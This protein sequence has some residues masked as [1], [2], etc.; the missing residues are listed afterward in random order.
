M[1]SD[2]PAVYMATNTVNG[3]RYIGATA[4]GFGA[5]KRRHL[6]RRT[7]DRS[8]PRFYDAIN[9]YGEGAF[10]WK[11]LRTF[12]SAHCAFTFER[13]AIH[14]LKPEYNV[15]GGGTGVLGLPAWNRTSVI[16]LEDGIVYTS[17][18]NAAAAYDASGGDLSEI[19][20]GNRFS[21]KGRHFSRFSKP[22]SEAERKAEI[23]RMDM[24][25]IG[26]RRRRGGNGL[27]RYYRGVEAGRDKKGRRA[28][29]PMKNSRAIICLDTGEIFES[30]N[31]AGRYFDLNSS[32]IC[33]AC[34]GHQGR[35]TA[36][37]YRFSYYTDTK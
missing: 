17:M 19:C 20:N 10:E 34:S 33:G 25:K 23:R 1:Q 4:K 24:D 11:I 37:G 2:C 18:A 16:C 28:T 27:T 5:R 7:V 36:G 6:F 9:K 31:A 35:K 3:K 22:M 21:V 30:I 15:T 32:A 14:I 12:K 29:G 8:C 26:L 13:I